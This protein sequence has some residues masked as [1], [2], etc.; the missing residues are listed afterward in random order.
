MIFKLTVGDILQSTSTNSKSTVGDILQSTSTIH[1]AT[2]CYVYTTLH[3][4]ATSTVHC[5]YTKLRY[6]YVYATRV[7]TTLHLQYTVS[8]L[9]YGT[10]TSTLHRGKRRTLCGQ[11][12]RIRLH[13]FRTSWP[14]RL[15]CKSNDCRRLQSSNN[16][17]QPTS[18]YRS[19]PPM[20]I[21]RRN[22]NHRW[23]SFADLNE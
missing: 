15:V 18:T 8:A 3:L 20:D 6:I 2:I 19:Q 13:K 5:V 12:V 4:Y 1:Y 9:N 22:L 7:Y 17:H 10:S 23:I 11:S 16:S 21:S 14:K